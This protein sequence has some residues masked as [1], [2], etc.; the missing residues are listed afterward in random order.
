M[1]WSSVV[2][3]P[4]QTRP[5]IRFVSSRVKSILLTDG[6]VEWDFGWASSD[7]RQKA[8]TY[9]TIYNKYYILQESI[10]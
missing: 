10:T 4:G 7:A 8:T 3:D 9:S 5:S 2:I 1:I 6:S